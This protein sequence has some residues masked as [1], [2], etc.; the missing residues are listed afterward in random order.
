M[1]GFTPLSL[2]FTGFTVVAFRGFS[3]AINV[4]LVDAF[5]VIACTANNWLVKTMRHVNDERN[6]IVSLALLSKTN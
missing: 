6:I 1:K 5:A 4:P 2:K 3:L